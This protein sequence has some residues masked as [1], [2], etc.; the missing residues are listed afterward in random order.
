VVAK[1]LFPIPVDAIEARLD[2]VIH[3]SWAKLA[4]RFN[5]P[6]GSPMVA[7]TP[8]QSGSWLQA[9]YDT[10]GAQ[11]GTEAVPLEICDAVTGAPVFG[12]PLIIRVDEGQRIVEFADAGLTDYNAPLIGEGWT[13]GSQTPGVV[14]TPQALHVLLRKHLPGCDQ[15]QFRKMPAKLAGTANPFAYLSGCR[16]SDVGTNVVTVDGS[17]SEYRAR[18]A[19]KIRKELE[20]SLRVFERDG[21]DAKFYQVSD[22]TEAVSVL[23]RMEVLQAERMR[24]LK[25]PFVLNEPQYAAFYRRLIELDLANGR[26]L[27]TVLR[28]EPDEVVGALLG[29][30]DDENY[31]MVRLAHAGKSW[32]HCSPGKLIIDQTM[33]HLHASGVTRFDFTTGDY[34]YKKGF[35]TESESLMDV[36]L[37]LSIDG[38]LKLARAMAVSGVKN[39]MRRFPRTFEWLKRLGS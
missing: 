24:E 33:Q 39:Q 8:F 36:S 11:V 21:T 4:T 26:L 14:V 23:E 16:P 37:G 18:L 22:A 15:L 12:V 30:V 7:A 9:W 20:R 17:W 29:L 25:L 10:L 34:T 6:T 38:R 3:P 32:S 13:F 1:A 2:A 31:A 5:S 35:L 27:L 28:S 19:K